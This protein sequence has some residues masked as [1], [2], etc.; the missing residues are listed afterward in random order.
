MD[1]ELGDAVGQSGQ[2]LAH[3]RDVD[4]AAVGEAQDRVV[5]PDTGT[6]EPPLHRGGPVAQR[7]GD[8]PIAHPLAC[9]RL[10]PN[11][12]G[13]VGHADRRDAKLAREPHEDRLHRRM[14]VEMMVA[15]DVVEVEPGPTE[16]GKLCADLGLRLRLRTAAEVDA[17]AH[18][19]GIARKASIGT[20]Q[21]RDLLGR[22]RR[23]AVDQHEV[24]PDG[25]T[26][27]AP[28]ALDRIRRGGRR[29]HQ[30]RGCQD[31][32]EMAELDRLVHGNGQPKIIGGDDQSLRHYSSHPARVMTAERADG[33]ASDISHALKGGT[34]ATR[35]WSQTSRV[36]EQT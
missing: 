1:I 15:I 29:H 9:A 2:E 14:Q 5:E 4:V 34:S 22:Q 16:R 31:A 36:H 17:S 23:P 21:I 11:H 24:Q 18:A 26:R 32:V 19:H 35:A 28:C 6:R 27:Q 33:G 20:N 30:A 25:E 12:G 10:M 13:L 7:K 3:A 8:Q